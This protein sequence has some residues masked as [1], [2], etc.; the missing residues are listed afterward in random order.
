MSGSRRPKNERQRQQKKS[1]LNEFQLNQFH[2]E[3]RVI[4]ISLADEISPG[5]LIARQTPAIPTRT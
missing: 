4:P 2:T 5:D 1:E 3:L